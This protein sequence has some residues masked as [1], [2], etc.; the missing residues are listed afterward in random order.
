MLD[1]RFESKSS[2]DIGGAGKFLFWNF[3]ISIKASKSL[4][5]YEYSNCRCMEM[6]QELASS[7]QSEGQFTSSASEMFLQS[8]PSQSQPSQSQRSHSSKILSALANERGS[9]SILIFTL[10]FLL[11]LSAFVTADASDAFLAKREL[12]GV[13]EMAITRAAHQISME[14]YYSGNIMMDTSGADGPLFRVPIDC[15]AAFSAFNL[16]ID[17]SNLRGSPII[18]NSWNCASDG[19][20][21]T[22]SSMVPA[23]IRFPLGIGISINHVSSTIGATSIIGGSR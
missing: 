10:F 12:V 21:A 17:G 1:S 2:G 23:L 20:K 6:I 14:R 22:I 7:M 8:Q 13:G 3:S 15:D 19:V 4:E 5:R 16:E 9:L 18:V 11:L